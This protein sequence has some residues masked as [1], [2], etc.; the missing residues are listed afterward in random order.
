MV[1]FSHRNDDEQRCVAMQI[2]EHHQLLPAPL[3]R[4]MGHTFVQTYFRKFILGAIFIQLTGSL[5]ANTLQAK[6]ALT[7]QA[8]T[9]STSHD[10]DFLIGNWVVHHR[11]LNHRLVHSDEWETF[12][13]TCEMQV[14]LG[15]LANVDDNVLDAPEGKYTAA[16]L[17]AFDPAA[18]KWSIWWLDGRH[19]NHLDPPVVGEFRKG[20]GVFIADDSWD[21][22]PIKVRFT[23]SDITPNSARWEQAFS[24]DGGVIW[25]TN[26][27]MEFRRVPSSRAQHAIAK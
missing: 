24:Q 18:K 25:E 6:T 23:W 2:I 1:A 4:L 5:F 17:R 22:K 19:P 9:V 15:G 13:G 16:S 12:S 26:W 7:P 10:F 14:L 8:E 3:E 21:G 27:I 20:V 11:K